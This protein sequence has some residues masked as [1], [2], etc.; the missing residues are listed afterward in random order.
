MCTDQGLVTKARVAEGTGFIFLLWRQYGLPS[1]V[2]KRSSSFL[3]IQDND[4]VFKIILASPLT[5]ISLLS[6]N[7]LNLFSVF[8]S[9]H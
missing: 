9:E 1:R 2:Q 7:R 8:S 6:K 5:P 4:S 3:L